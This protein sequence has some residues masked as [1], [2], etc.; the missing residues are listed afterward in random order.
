MVVIPYNDIRHERYITQ[1]LL[2]RDMEMKGVPE[3]GF[4]TFHEGMPVAAGF[5]RRIEGNYGQIDSVITDPEKSPEVRDEALDVLTTQL[6]IAAKDMKLKGLTAYITD[7]NT[8]LRSNRHGFM[9]VPHKITML[10][11]SRGQL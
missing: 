5:I 10:D 8:L 4:M 1:W 9:E 7:N 6:I 2:A 11:L 3:T